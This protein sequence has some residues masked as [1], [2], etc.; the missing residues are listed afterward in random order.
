MSEAVIIDDADH[1]SIEGGVYHIGYVEMVDGY[2]HAYR[3]PVGKCGHRT[4][5]RYSR[6]PNHPADPR[7][8]ECAAKSN[9]ASA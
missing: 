5:I 7:C 4:V 8:P 6:S 1:P 3:A 2:R 9:E